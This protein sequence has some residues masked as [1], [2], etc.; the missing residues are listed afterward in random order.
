MCT[1][2]EC[3][4]NLKIVQ[5]NKDLLESLISAG[6]VKQLLG[7]ER[8]RADAV[9]WSYD[10]AGHA[11]KCEER[12]NEEKIERTVMSLL[13]VPSTPFPPIFSPPATSLPTPILSPSLSAG[14]RPHPCATS[15][16]D[17]LPG[18]LANPIPKTVGELSK[19]RHKW[20]CHAFT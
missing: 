17:G 16:G 7:W 11:K 4:H 1:Q 18:R 12:Y 8:S 3:K 5:E 9:A 10:M 14:I 15:L 2:R 6:I 19:N 20:S 13:N